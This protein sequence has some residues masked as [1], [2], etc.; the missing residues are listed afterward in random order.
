MFAKISA[1][2][3][4]TMWQQNYDSRYIKKN[5]HVTMLSTKSIYSNIAV[6]ENFCV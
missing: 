1:V 4:G 3:N 5:G 6:F 2:N